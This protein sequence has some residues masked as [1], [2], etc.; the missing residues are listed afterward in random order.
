MLSEKFDRYNVIIVR[1]SHKKVF[2]YSEN[3]FDVFLRTTLGSTAE[4]MNSLARKLH[5]VHVFGGC[6]EKVVVSIQRNGEQIVDLL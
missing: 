3:I 6:V 1:Y 2:F 4:N 5:T